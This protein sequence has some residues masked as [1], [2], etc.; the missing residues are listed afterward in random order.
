[1]NSF[2]IFI[3]KSKQIMGNI[4]IDSIE[5]LI[6]VRRNYKIKRAYSSFYFI[7]TL[8]VNL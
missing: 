1:M 8:L 5:W 3:V 7:V 6:E 4:Y 2:Y